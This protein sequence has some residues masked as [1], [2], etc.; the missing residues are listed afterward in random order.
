MIDYFVM[1]N[2]YDIS[3]ESEAAKWTN[4]DSRIGKKSNHDPREKKSP[5]YGRQ[6]DPSARCGHSLLKGLFTYLRLLACY[7]TEGLFTWS[8]H[9]GKSMTHK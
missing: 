1:Q 7:A 3:K 2:W 4:H 6:S 9:A 8:Y 5:N